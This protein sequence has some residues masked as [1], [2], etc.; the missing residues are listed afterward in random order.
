MFSSQ[1]RN[2][3]PFF[4]LE[5]LTNY[6]LDGK[7]ANQDKK[8][9]PYICYNTCATHLSQWL[10]RKKNYAFWNTHDLEIT[11]RSCQWLL[12][13]HGAF[14]CKGTVKEKEIDSSIIQTLNQLCTLPPIIKTYQLQKHRNHIKLN[15]MMDK[16]MSS[17]DHMIKNIVQHLS[18]TTHNSMT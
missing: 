3:T 10:T 13:L 7:I 6:I 4:F 8:W 12:L 16:T 2:I 18:A 9:A 17:I 5:N 1:K 14:N 11:D 15:Q